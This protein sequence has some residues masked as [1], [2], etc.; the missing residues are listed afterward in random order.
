MKKDDELAMMSSR[1]FRDE[2]LVA[3]SSVGRASQSPVSSTSWA[4]QR[5]NLVGHLNKQSSKSQ[6][7]NE[8]DSSSSVDEHNGHVDEIMRHMA[9]DNNPRTPPQDLGCSSSYIYAGDE[10]TS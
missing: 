3:V 4:N 7:Q 8:D 2:Y 1:N 10:N 9:D 5:L 6:L